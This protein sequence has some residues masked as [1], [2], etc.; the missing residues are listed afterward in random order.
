LARDLQY[1]IAR[2]YVAKLVM[3]FDMHP[4][5]QHIECLAVLERK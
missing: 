5:T 1:L 3:P 2:G 4:G